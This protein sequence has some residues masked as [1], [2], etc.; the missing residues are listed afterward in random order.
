MIGSGTTESSGELAAGTPK[1]EATKKQSAGSAGFVAG[2]K[3]NGAGH[4]VYQA[5]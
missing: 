2:A 1:D 3:K 4:V 5:A